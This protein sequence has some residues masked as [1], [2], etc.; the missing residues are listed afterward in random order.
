[1]E[2]N[3]KRFWGGTKILSISRGS[4]ILG[5][6]GISLAVMPLYGISENAEKGICPAQQQVVSQ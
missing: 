4:A 6:Y 1:M 3:Q 5:S 2:L